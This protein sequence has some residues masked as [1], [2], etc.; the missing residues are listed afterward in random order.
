V[1]ITVMAISIHRPAVSGERVSTRA[2]LRA[3]FRSGVRAMV[4]FLV[5]LTP[6]ALVIGAT[7]ARSGPFVPRL[8]STVLI[9]GGSAQLAVLQGLD[10]GAALWAVVATGVVVNA[11]LLAYSASLSAMWAD[12]SRR[13]RAL[14]AAAIVDPTWAMVRHRAAA[15]SRPAAIRTYYAGAASSLCAGWTLLVITG[16][17]TGTVV[18][19]GAVALAAPLSLAV[20]VL[21]R[22]AQPGG[23][24]L[25]AATAG[26]ALLVGSLPAGMDLVVAIGTGLAASATRAA[27]RRQ[28]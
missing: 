24:A 5:G 20:L 11:R 12:S 15:G 21:P 18:S 27:A 13:F 25:V 8:L 22:L 10:R 2:D 28:P 3:E 19:G 14:A 26:A 4:P 1:T 6:F 16:A 7:V 17:L 9:M 23:R